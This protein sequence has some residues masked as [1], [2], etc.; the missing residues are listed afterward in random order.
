[1]PGQILGA[2]T[3]GQPFFPKVWSYGANG[4]VDPR[5]PQPVRR[6]ADPLTSP[7]FRRHSIHRRLHLSK[8]IGICCDEL[9]DST[10]AIQIPG[11]IYLAR[12]LEPFDR[13]AQFQ[14]DGSRRV[15][16]WKRQALADR[17]LGRSIGRRLDYQWIDNVLFGPSLFSLGF[18]RLAGRAGQ[19]ATRQSDQARC[20]IFGNIGATVSYFDPLAFAPVTTPTFG[21]VGYNT[22]RGPNAT[23]LDLGLFRSFSLTERW[24]LEFRAEALNFTN[25]PH[26]GLP[27]GNMSNL[28]LNADGTIRSLGGFSTITSVVGVGR[29]GVDERVVRFGL[30]ITF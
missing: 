20:E 11:L 16:F 25:S 2:G 22:L 12:A 14:Y 13:H 3:A 17:G 8:A 29:E 28:Q 30:R 5:R 15:A 6:A 23:N 4:C 26:F 21:T 27:N 19:R 1:M 18:G 24:K 10:P 7:I 9:S